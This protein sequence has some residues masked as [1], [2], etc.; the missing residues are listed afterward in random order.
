M[1]SEIERF[2]IDQVESIIYSN[3]ASKLSLSTKLLEIIEVSSY[4]LKT[5][6]TINELS[7]KKVINELS[8]EWLAEHEQKM[9]EKNAILDQINRIGDQQADAKM[10]EKSDISEFTDDEDKNSEASDSVVIEEDAEQLL[11]RLQRDESI[12]DDSSGSS[13]VLRPRAD[14]RRKKRDAELRR[15][16][17]RALVVEDEKGNYAMN[18]ADPIL[19]SRKYHNRMIN[20]AIKI[21]KQRTEIPYYDDVVTVSREYRAATDIENRLYEIIYLLGN[22]NTQPVVI[23]SLLLAESSITQTNDY[24]RLLQ[25]LWARI[26][27][28]R[29]SF[30][31]SV[32]LSFYSSDIIEGRRFVKAPENNQ[33]P[34]LEGIKGALMSLAVDC[35]GLDLSPGRTFASML[36]EIG[37]YRYRRHVA[38]AQNQENV[39]IFY[40]FNL[41]HLNPQTMSVSDRFI[42]APNSPFDQMQRSVM[43]PGQPFENILGTVTVSLTD[44]AIWNQEA[45]GC[46]IEFCRVSAIIKSK[47]PVVARDRCFKSTEE[48]INSGFHHNRTVRSML[49]FWKAAVLAKYMIMVPMTY[50]YPIDGLNIENRVDVNVLIQFVTLLF[51]V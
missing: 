51:F 24:K 37:N 6:T 30:I 39:G 33:M 1:A 26:P 22:S 3:L 19:E 9:R 15:A 28:V 40:R 13:F 42:L 44:N 25:V 11:Q 45:A 20:L 47:A 27:I 41:A 5:D 7:Q 8:P 49:I 10:E 2:V 4:A 31:V 46:I 23:R 14:A 43:N 17:R 36:A 16:E 50:P 21:K 48:L 18:I 32:I 34:A 35:P 12:T 29:F 38:R